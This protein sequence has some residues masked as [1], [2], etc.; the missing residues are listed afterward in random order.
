MRQGGWSAASSGT[1]NLAARGGASG[2]TVSVPPDEGFVVRLPDRASDAPRSPFFAGCGS[3]G[4]F[5]SSPEDG[6]D[7]GLRG[8]WPRCPDNCVHEA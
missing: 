8:S 1:P 7:G 5:A 6:G 4:S 3:L 2:L